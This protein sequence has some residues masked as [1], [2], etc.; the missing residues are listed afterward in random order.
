MKLLL[1]GA[2]FYKSEQKSINQSVGG[3]MSSTPVPSGR[4]NLLFGDVSI[5]S[6]MVGSKDCMAIYAYND[7]SETIT[8]LCIEQIQSANNDCEFYWGAVDP[9]DNGET[10]FIEKI[11][12]RKEEPFNVDWFQPTTKREN[13]TVIIK[14]AGLTGDVAELLDVEF[15]LTGNTKETLVNDIVK[16]F[17]NNETYN[18]HKVSQESFYIERIDKNFTGE[19]IELITP[20]NAEFFDKNFSGGED[21]STLILEE[22]LPGKAIAFWVKR[23]VVQN[24]ECESKTCEDLSCLKNIDTKENLEV[25]FSYD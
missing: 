21:G 15:D 12:S 16:A 8:N 2:Q 22:L 25:I 18:C 1:S 7:S 4:I 10:I 6:K 5:Y 20:G 23:E 11:G 19:P 9:N 17:K 3:Y 24:E 13:A 14:S